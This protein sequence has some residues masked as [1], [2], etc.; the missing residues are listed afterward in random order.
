[1]KKIVSVLLIVLLTMSLVS[2]NIDLNNKESDITIYTVQFINQNGEI[3]KDIEV[4]EGSYI[5]NIP[6]PATKAD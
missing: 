2:C 3:I 4:E 6:E 5:T 1:M